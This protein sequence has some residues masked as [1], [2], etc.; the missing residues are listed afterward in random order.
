[1]THVLNSEIICHLF[2]AFINIEIELL[3]CGNFDR[4][5]AMLQHDFI[6]PPSGSSSSSSSI[7]FKAWVKSF[8]QKRNVFSLLEK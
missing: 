5:I 4:L 2:G 7:D 6:A 3:S 1:M 8:Y